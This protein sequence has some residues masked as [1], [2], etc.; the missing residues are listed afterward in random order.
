MKKIAFLLAV[1]LVAVMPL[2]VL[3]ETYRIAE[4]YDV[5]LTFSGTTANCR[6]SVEANEPSYYL[7]VTMKLY[8]GNQLLKQWSQS[9]NG[10]VYLQKTHTVTKG[11][12]YKLTMEL[13]VN[14][15]SRPSRS[16]TKTC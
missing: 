5:N 15:T 13:M 16:V 1:V 8:H 7:V 11:Q 3:A 12:T 6:A 4:N 2:S 10:S 9:S 14:G